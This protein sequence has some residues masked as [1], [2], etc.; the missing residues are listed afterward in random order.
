MPS[1]VSDLVAPLTDAAGS[2]CPRAAAPTA[3]EPVFRNS[4]L[5]IIAS[6]SFHAMH[7]HYEIL[8]LLPQQKPRYFNIFGTH[9]PLS[10]NCVP[11][12]NGKG[13]NTDG[14]PQNEFFLVGLALL[15]CCEFIFFCKKR[16]QQGVYL[17]SFAAGSTS[18]FSK[19]RCCFT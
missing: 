16:E 15:S 1:A 3:T 14:S 10:G 5:F 19:Y 9:D 12:R 8:H 7:I 4:L 17:C 6:I 2:A 13:L 18:L 11:L